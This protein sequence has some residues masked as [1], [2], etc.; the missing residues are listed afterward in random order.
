MTYHRGANKIKKITTL[1]LFVV[2]Y[3]S[4]KRYIGT[5]LKTDWK[6]E[7]LGKE[8]LLQWNPVSHGQ[9]RFD[10]LI[11]NIV[12]FVTQFQPALKGLKNTLLDKWH[13]IQTSLI[14]KRHSRNAPLISYRKGAV[15]KDM[16]VKAKL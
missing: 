13:L 12:P 7:H 6:E 16:L 3:F 15:L 4:V 8:F 10:T 1:H 5:R 2:I 11:S 9:M 14:S